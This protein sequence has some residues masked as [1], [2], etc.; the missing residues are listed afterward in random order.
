IDLHLDVKQAVITEAVIFSDALNVE[1]IEALKES[2][3]GVKYNK[4]DIKAELNELKQMQPD[5]ADQIDDFCGWLI[6][7]IEN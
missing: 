5:L 7:E 1:L 4:D 2:L 6:S 3:T